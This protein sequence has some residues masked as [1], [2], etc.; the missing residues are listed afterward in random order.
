MPRNIDEKS[1][2]P[3]DGEGESTKREEAGESNDAVIVDWDGPKDP[4]N[5]KNWPYRRKWAATLVVSS[6]TFISPVSSSMVAPATSQVAS[7]FGVTQNVV[8]AMMTSIFVLG[9]AMGPLFLGPLSEIYGRSRVLQLSNLFYLAWNLGCGFAQNKGQFI[10]FRFLSGL[11]GSAPLSIGGG[12][13]GDVWHPEERGKAIA[14]YSLAPLL[15]PVVGP[16]CGAWIAERST[17]RWVFWSTSIVDAAIQISGLFFLQETYAPLLLE[18]KAEQIRRTL[19]AEKGEKKDVHTV[20]EAAGERSWSQIFS[21]ALT[22]PFVLFAREEIVQ[23]FGIYMAFIYGLFYLFLT[24][25]PAIFEGTYRQK[26]SIAG[27]HYIALGVGLTLASQINA[28]YMDRIYIHFKRKNNGV[29]E[30]EFR[31]PSMVPGT[32]ILPAGLL[33]AGWAAQE[34]VHWIVTDIGIAFVGAGIILLF[35]SIQTYVVDAFTLHA[36]SAQVHLTISILIVNEENKVVLVLDIESNL[37]SLDLIRI[38][39]KHVLSATNHHRELQYILFTVNYSEFAII[40]LPTMDPTNSH[41]RSARSRRPAA[42]AVA[43]EIPEDI[44]LLTQP[45]YTNNIRSGPNKGTPVKS[46]N[47]IHS[48]TG[49]REQ[50][51]KGFTS[52]LF[53]RRW[54]SADLVDH[55]FGNIVSLSLA[56]RI[57]LSFLHC[58]LLT[59]ELNSKELTK[60]EWPQACTDAA[61]W[62]HAVSSG[63]KTSEME[64]GYAWTW[65]KKEFG[66]GTELGAENFFNA[67]GMAAYLSAG[68]TDHAGLQNHTPTSRFTTSPRP[69]YALPLQPP[70]GQDCQPDLIVLPSS[71]F[72]SFS[73]RDPTRLKEYQG[74]P[75]AVRFIKSN[76]PEL[77]QCSPALS[78]LV[79]AKSTETSPR[80]DFELPPDTELPPPALQFADT[81]GSNDNVAALT[82]EEPSAID[83]GNDK[84]E[85]RD[86][87]SSCVDTPAELLMN[88]KELSKELDA[89]QF[90]LPPKWVVDAMTKHH[91]SD[92]LDMSRVCFPNILLAGEAKQS[93]IKAAVVQCSVYMRQQR[94]TQP[95]LR[96][97]LGLMVT[98]NKLGILRADAMGV[99]EC[100][101]EKDIGRGVIE[102]IRLALGITLATDEELGLHPAFSLRDTEM[103]SVSDLDAKTGKKRPAPSTNTDDQPDLKKA[104]TAGASPSTRYPAPPAKYR[105]REVNFVTLENS[106]LHLPGSQVSTGNHTRYYTKYLLEDRGSLVGRSTRI[107]C[108]YRE[109][110]GSERESLASVH[111]IDSHMPIFIGPYALK[112]YCADIQTEAYTQDI[113]IKAKKAQDA[114]TL[115]HVLL[116]TDVW[117]M[118]KTLDVVRSLGGSVKMLKVTSFALKDREEI[119]TIS[120]FKRTLAQFETAYE[121]YGAIIGVLKAI[122]ELQDA[123]IMHRDIS[124]GNIVLSDE[125]YA[126]P[127]KKCESVNVDF[128]DGNS[129]EAVLVRRQSAPMPSSGGLHDLDMAASI[130]KS[131]PKLEDPVLWTSKGFKK[132]SKPLTN[133]GN[134]GPD[135]RTGTTPFMSIPLLS[136]EQNSVYDDLQS[137]FFVLYLSMLT[138]DTPAPNC[139]PEAPRTTLPH[140]PTKVQRWADNYV[141]MED[142]GTR[143]QKFFQSDANWL[144]C[145][146]DNGLKFWLVDPVDRLLDECHGA[147]LLEFQ[148]AIWAK[149]PKSTGRMVL[150]EKLEVKPREVAAALERI[151]EKHKDRLS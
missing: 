132:I 39:N 102:A 113:L 21:K 126:N 80:L 135:F 26:K 35:Q 5:P 13:L 75:S 114:G 7:D 33:I 78:A 111:K 15:G 89:K 22:R 148:Q 150:F 129:V 77:F 46:S 117:Y 79:F 32:V 25:M 96:F 52:E 97:C 69:H 92:Y 18:R 1:L 119:V 30:P 151:V 10:A 133:D 20:F 99:E 88:L 112:F 29:G 51:V 12:V 115:K 31:L 23:L 103:P 40:F 61:S 70:D 85:I 139:Y 3:T 109:V 83:D 64:K 55:A 116:P 67:V 41:N 47:M 130:P 84:T 28:R 138:F 43:V 54:N 62:A 37:Y 14:I 145:L 6:F 108:A 19:D 34:H 82:R 125:K 137:T 105:Y 81:T 17:W 42:I 74:K 120:P 2:T 16:V 49:T 90:P 68:I 48:G 142:L 149:V 9:Y 122:G 101:F 106:K 4:A 76:F 50:V 94:R 58:K 57:M 86:P 44:T 118:G 8:I 123:G 72:V 95:W 131:V 38:A 71:A 73:E 53:G 121:F 36:A 56:A 98:K 127:D 45:R 147:A 140:W 59:V 11:G 65:N 91:D 66:T 143:K 93:D 146:I 107:W 128:G 136:G 124:F 63:S 87:Y 100:F 110:S 144:V 134:I 141:S 104:R 24:T 27:L 60:E